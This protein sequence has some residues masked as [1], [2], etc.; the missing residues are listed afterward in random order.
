M[1]QKQTVAMGKSWAIST[2]WRG[3]RARANG[4]GILAAGGRGWGVTCTQA[5]TAGGGLPGQDLGGEGILLNGSPPLPSH[6]PHLQGGRGLGRVSSP[7][8]CSATGAGRMLHRIERLSSCRSSTYGGEGRR[9]TLRPRLRNMAVVRW[10]RA[11]LII[12]WVQ[13]IAFPKRVAFA[14]GSL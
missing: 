5:G 1:S 10:S 4:P 13:D 14:K 3:P 2:L 12:E 11:V 8:S 6:R 7:M 9:V